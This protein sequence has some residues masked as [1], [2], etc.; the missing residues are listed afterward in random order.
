MSLGTTFLSLNARPEIFHIKIKCAVFSVDIPS[1]LGIDVMVE[2]C[3]MTYT[4]TNH[5]VERTVLQK[6]R[7]F[8][9]YVTDDWK[10]P[11]IIVN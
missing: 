2:H 9:F 3:L 4:V 8:F 5:P 7:K 11:L 1:L 10:V 6:E